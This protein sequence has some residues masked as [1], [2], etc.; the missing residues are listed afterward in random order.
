M[1]LLRAANRV[2]QRAVRELLVVPV[3]RVPERAVPVDTV[4]HVVHVHPEGIRLDGLV[5]SECHC[6]DGGLQNPVYCTV[7][8]K[9]NERTHAVRLLP[10]ECP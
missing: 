5:L 4:A 6:F 1:L 10:F 9:L 8:I 2:L 3:E 7:A